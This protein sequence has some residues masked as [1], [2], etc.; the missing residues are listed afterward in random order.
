[1]HKFLVEKKHLFQFGEKFKRK[2]CLLEQISDIIGF[3]IILDNIED[4]YKA[5]GIFHSKWHCIPGKV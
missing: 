1:M 5:L 3:R 2:E 4:C